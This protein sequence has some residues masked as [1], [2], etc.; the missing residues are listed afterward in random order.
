[1][2]AD[3]IQENNLTHTKD[4]DK[5]KIQK[6]I[7]KHN[8]EKANNAKHSKTKLPWFSCLLTALGEETSWAYSTTLPKTTRGNNSSSM[9][10]HIHR[11]HNML[12]PVGPSHRS[13]SQK[14]LKL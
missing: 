11:E 13:I 7:Q 1:M 3:I 14:Q 9:Q 5:L 10:Q 8:P 6:L 4:K 2:H 12:A